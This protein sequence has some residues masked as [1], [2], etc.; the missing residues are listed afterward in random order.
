MKLW[1]SSLT[2]LLALLSLSFTM[3]CVHGQADDN[4]AE[5]FKLF[6]PVVTNNTTDNE[7]DQTINDPALLNEA[8]V[9]LGEGISVDVT[10]AAANTILAPTRYTTTSGAD[11][12]Q[13]VAGLSVLDSP[14]TANSADWQKYLELYTPATTN[15][16]GYRTYS[17]PSNIAPTAITGIQ[18]KA[19]YKGP[20]KSYQTW[21]WT[22]YNTVTKQ[23]VSIGNNTN[24]PSWQWYLFTFNATGTLQNYVNS[25]TREILVRLQ[26]T[27][28]KSVV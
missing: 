6:L 20:L 5:P 22:I 28:R 7:S 26:S 19:N 1:K 12:G 11:G 24:A 25:T 13:S 10:A 14:N 15:Y 27:D 8:F 4:N 3:L 18:L 17:L 23:W 2:L 16:V 9:D 21:T